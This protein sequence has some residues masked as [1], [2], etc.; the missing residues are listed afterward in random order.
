MPQITVS[1][2]VLNRLTEFQRLLGVVVGEHV[3][4]NVCAEVVL[5]RGMDWMLAEIVAPTGAETLLTTIQKLGAR[6][7]AEVYRF[8]AEAIVAGMNQQHK[9]TVKQK[10]GFPPPHPGQV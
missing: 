7:P 9:E 8:V 5:G 3:C 6:H 1:D 4:T 2:D 10:I